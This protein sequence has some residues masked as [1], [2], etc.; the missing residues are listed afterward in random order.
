MAIFPLVAFVTAGTVC[1]FIAY[2]ALRMGQTQIDHFA[3]LPFND[4]PPIRHDAEL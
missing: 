4:Q 1:A 2:K 3:A